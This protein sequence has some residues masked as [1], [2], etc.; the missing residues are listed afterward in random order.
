[1]ALIQMMERSG[2]LTM[3]VLGGICKRGK[4]GQRTYTTRTPSNRLFARRRSGRP[5]T[6]VTS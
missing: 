6:T 3:Q 5:V 2:H 4:S 1:M